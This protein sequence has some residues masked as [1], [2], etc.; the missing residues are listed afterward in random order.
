MLSVFCNAFS[1]LFI[2]SIVN[3]RVYLTSEVTDLISQEIRKYSIV[4]R[5]I[6]LLCVIE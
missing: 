5:Y 4:L 2:I 6:S 1:V 3:I